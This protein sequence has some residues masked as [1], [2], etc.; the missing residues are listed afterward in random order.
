[1]A[2]LVHGEPAG[3]HHGRNAMTIRFRK[4]LVPT[5]MTLAMLVVLIWLGMWQLERQA[6]KDKILANLALPVLALQPSAAI[7][8]ALELRR[9][10]LTCGATGFEWID[11]PDSDGMTTEQRVFIRCPRVGPKSIMIDAGY[12][13][14]V[15]EGALAPGR[16]IEGTIRK[17]EP[18]QWAN[19]VAGVTKVTRTQFG[20]AQAVSEFYLKTGSPPQLANI[21]NNHFMYALQWFLFAGVLG[22][23]YGIFV[24]RTWRET[25]SR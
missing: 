24:R 5:V 6:W 15:T 16:V 8:E 19:K 17:W 2:K 25:L 20:P 12:A 13:T 21:S 1:M 10:R 7:G 23:I 9:V 3:L 22:V 11:V 4:L 14:Q 18:E